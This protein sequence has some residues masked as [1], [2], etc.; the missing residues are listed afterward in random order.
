MDIA[1]RSKV[2]EVGSEWM[3]S[4]FWLQ[5]QSQADFN[6]NQQLQVDANSRL[7]IEANKDVNTSQRRI[8]NIRRS[9]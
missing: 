5:Y 6:A 1:E 4:G 8:L 7:W 9:D 2:N 3:G